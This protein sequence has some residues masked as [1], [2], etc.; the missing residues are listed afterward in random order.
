MTG[1][2]AELLVPD[3]HE[4]REATMPWR[5]SLSED[6]SDDFAELWWCD[7]KLMLADNLTK[8]ITPSTESFK[9]VLRTNKISLGKLEEGHKRPRETQR[10]HA[11]E[12]DHSNELT[13]KYFFA[14]YMLRDLVEED[15]EICHC[16][17]CKDWTKTVKFS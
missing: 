8:L 14:L 9:E 12:A 1:K 5:N 11:F 4:L 10:A 7:T 2:T 17:G 13:A 3:I 16:P 6:Y 15:K